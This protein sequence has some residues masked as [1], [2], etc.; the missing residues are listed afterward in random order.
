M[1]EQRSSTNVPLK[2]GPTEQEKGKIVDA[3]KKANRSWN[4][5]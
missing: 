1:I 5:T 3:E 4:P 2:I